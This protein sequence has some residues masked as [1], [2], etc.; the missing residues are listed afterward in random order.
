MGLLTKV[1]EWH[2]NHIRGHYTRDI[3]HDL[4]RKSEMLLAEVIA[5][6]IREG[7][8]HPEEISA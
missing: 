2:Y 8:I 4:T 3:E 6:Q 1:D 5:N 7:T